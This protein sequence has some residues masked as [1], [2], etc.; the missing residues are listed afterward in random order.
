MRRSAVSAKRCKHAGSFLQQLDSYALAAGAAG[1]SLL[2]LAEP[3]E[4]RIVYTPAHKVIGNGDSYKLDFN[5]DGITD[6]SIRNFPGSYCTSDG[7]CHPIESLGAAPSGRNQVVYN[8]YGAVA[9]KAGMKIGRSCAFKGGVQRMV[10]SFGSVAVGSWINVT[11]RYLGVRF[12]IKGQMHYG[13]ARL[14]VRLN[15]P[16]NITATLTGYAYETVPNKAIIAGRTKG[17]EVMSTAG[18]ASLGRLAQGSAG[19]A[20]WRQ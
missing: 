6:L 2:A 13:W 5:H 12:K 3:S 8:I 18:P 17:P 20:A 16:R 19:L 11:N 15:P 10:W 1:V 7:S 14:D 4:A 9:M